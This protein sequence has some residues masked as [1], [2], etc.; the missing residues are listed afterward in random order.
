MMSGDPR[1]TQI[2]LILEPTVER[3]YL[4]IPFELLPGTARLKIEY[5]YQRHRED[6]S[7]PHQSFRREVNIVDLALEDWQHCLVGASGS[8]RRSIEIHENYATDGYRPAVLTPGKWFVL[9]G[10]YMVEQGGCPV[11]I[12]IDQAVKEP[13]LLKGDTHLHS[14]HSDG[15]Y[16]V[17]EVI[18]RA[19]QDRLDYI[20]LTDHNCMSSNAH[21]VSDEQLIVIPGV[22]ITYYNGHYNLLGQGR[23][24]RTFFANHRDEVLAI[25]QEGRS[26]KA[27]ASIN[28]PFDDSCGWHYGLDPSVEVDLLEVWNGPFM[29]RNAKAI[30]FWQQQLVAGRRWPIIGGSDNHRNNQFLL[31]GNPSTFVFADSHCQSDILAA[32]QAGHSFIGSTPDAPEIELTAGPARMGDIAAIGPSDSIC[33]DVRRLHAQDEI[34]LITEAG[35]VHRHTVGTEYGCRIERT[36]ADARFYRVE[37]WRQIPGIAETLAS[38]SNPIYRQSGEK[39]E[40]S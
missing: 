2:D 6:H 26:N 32:L 3:Q 23:P 20:F 13:V 35:I 10:A 18:N 33:L 29:L 17:D 27:L 28:H 8:E 30:A 22:E 9:I 34:R 36:W 4:R 31:M 15:W 19:R 5:R 14:T 11:T 38:I 16:T 40:W 7:D 24:V 37:I 1:H 12:L 39:S 21:L 25:M